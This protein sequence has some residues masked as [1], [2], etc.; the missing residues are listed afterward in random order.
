MSLSHPREHSYGCL[1]WKPEISEEKTEAGMEGKR[2]RMVE[3]HFQLKQWSKPLMN[4]G[5]YLLSV[6][7]LVRPVALIKFH[8]VTF[9]CHSSSSGSILHLRDECV[10]RVTIH[11]FPA[12]RAF[13]MRSAPQP[14]LMTHH[15]PVKMMDHQCL[16]QKIPPH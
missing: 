3:L 15:H 11:L 2:S 10:C 14:Q 1:Q 9:T 13:F 6:L 7:G 4:E 16:P 8:T 5:N 12:V